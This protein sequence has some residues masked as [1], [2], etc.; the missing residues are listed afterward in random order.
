MFYILIFIIIL[1]SLFLLYMNIRKMHVGII[2]LIMAAYF[3]SMLSIIIYLSRDTYYYNFLK[4][5]FYLPEFLWRKFFFLGISKFN[6]IRIMNFCSLIIIPLGIRF[7]LKFYF[8]LSNKAEYTVKVLSWINFILQFLLYEPQLNIFYYYQLYPQVLSVREYYFLQDYIYLGTRSINISFMLLS[9]LF[10]FLAFYKAPKLHLF[11][12]NYLY[13]TMGYGALG[14]V[15]LLFIS[16]VPTF[17]LNISKISDTYTYNSL[18]L[19]E[20]SFFY[21]FLTFFLAVA[22][23]MLT[24]ATIRISKLNRQ[25]MLE[26]LELSKEI[27]ASDTTSKIFCHYIKNEI[28]AIQ[29][30]L[31]LMNCHV[32]NNELVSDI[33]QR[34]NILYQRI[35]ELHHN[36]KTGQLCLRECSIQNL[37]STAVQPYRQKELGITISPN[38]PSTEIMGFIDETYMIQAIDNIIRN[39]ADAMMV[40][41]IDKRNLTITLNTSKDWISLQISDTGIGISP[42]N[43]K[44]IFTPFYSSHP[45]SQH[46]GIGLSLTYKIIHAHEGKIDI[47]SIPKEGTTVTLLLPLI[48][49]TVKTKRKKDKK[50]GK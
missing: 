48:Q 29:A 45:Y 28:L 35:D 2:Q 38:F 47:Q 6:I 46:W 32:E 4:S 37:I 19:N 21:Q 12:I 23:S 18:N 11:R 40:R 7:S 44:N 24:Y 27:S 5:Y 22:L 14:I 31:N 8:F 36:T 26:E 49:H 50:N 41:P 1:M 17:Y 33:Q 16:K 9:I 30:D 15:Y 25:V 10:L 34:C 3:L 20:P 42:E 39:S 13:L 43:M